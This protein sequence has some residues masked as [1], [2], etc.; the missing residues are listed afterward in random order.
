MVQ[1]Q[2]RQGTE[3][4][5]TPVGI[6]HKKPNSGVNWVSLWVT[7]HCADTCNTHA[8][9]GTDAQTGTVAFKGPSKSSIPAAMD[10]VRKGPAA[11]TQSG[12]ATLKQAAVGM[13]AHTL[14]C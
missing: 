1:H 14:S 2:R 13:S 9:G 3:E 7:H 11:A 12:A 4:Q 6:Y 8:G 5:S 10:S